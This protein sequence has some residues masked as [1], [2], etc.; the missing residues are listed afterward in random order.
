MPDSADARR[1]RLL[2]DLADTGGG[3]PLSDYAERHGA[4]DRTIRRDV[5]HLRDLV[6]AVQSIDIRR[7]RVCASRTAYAQGY[8]TEQMAANADRKVAMA[9]AVVDAL[10]DD[11]AIALTAGSSVYHVARE[12]RRR[13]IEDRRPANLIAFTNSLPALVELIGAD[14][15]TGV[16]GE[17][18]NADDCAF[19]SHDHRSAFQAA[20]A[21]VGAS[22]LTAGTSG[23]LELY[24]HR[25]EEAAFHR[26]LL[27]DIPEI[28]VVVDA[29]KVGRRHPWPF[30]GR[31]LVL[32]K[33]IR[34]YT[35]PL[36]PAQTDMLA[37]LADRA[38]RAGYSLEVTICT[39]EG[40]L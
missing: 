32:G 29:A 19:H 24:S 3:A 22:G 17:V 35:T 26:A 7:G 31:D 28:D 23:A 5:D 10:P 2:E 16:M 20:R 21:I 40:A 37:D 8:F 1:M 30:T 33:R 39:P 11:F 4:D 6:A 25:S 12:I 18:Y 9:R 13:R 36:A 14:V 15:H 34:L 27:R 38:P